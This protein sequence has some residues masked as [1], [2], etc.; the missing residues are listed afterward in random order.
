MAGNELEVCRFLLANIGQIDLNH[1]GI[2]NKI[3]APIKQSTNFKILNSEGDLSIVYTQDSRKKAD[4][5]LNGNGISI[6]QTG[7]SFAFNRIQRANIIALYHQLEFTDIENKL[8]L[9]D[10]DV[11]KFNQ[12]L[13]TSRNVPWQNYLL[14]QDFKK[15]LDFLMLRGSPNLGLSNYPAQY[16]LEAPASGINKNNIFLHSFNEYFEL[17]KNNLT[18]AIRRQWVGQSS[19]SEHKRA[20]SL[21]N[22]NDNLPWVFDR[23]VGKPRTGWRSNFPKSERKTVYFLMIE[24]K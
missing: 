11:K 18:I 8:A 20:L 23:V 17:Y 5:H 15:L 2:I 22:K 24:K 13:L 16:V 3:A 12:G 6:K 9:L 19:N 1:L 21:A 14:E 4:I 7:G 10:R